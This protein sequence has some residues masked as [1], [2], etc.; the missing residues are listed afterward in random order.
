V[1]SKGRRQTKAGT[2]QVFTCTPKDAT[3]HSFCVLVEVLPAPR[4]KRRGGEP[5]PP[6][7]PV[8]GHEDSWVV[9]K[10]TRTNK[11][12][13]YLLLRCT[14]TTGAAHLFRAVNGRAVAP[15]LALWVPPPRCP[16]HPGAHIVRDGLY[17]NSTNK[18][19]QRYRCYP[20]GRSG[21]HHRFTPT[22]PRAHVHVGHEECAECE[23]QRGM[24]RGDPTIS[25]RQS[26]SSRLVAEALRDL[27]A[28]ASYSM[29]GRRVRKVTKRKRSR[30]SDGKKRKGYPGQ[31]L[32]RN[33]WHIAADWCEIYSP[34]L[35]DH[36]E[37][38]MR[39]RT[40][41]AI[42]ERER[43]VLA[44]QPN[45][46]PLALLIDDIPI[47][48]TFTDKDT[49]RVTRR[50]YF[51]LI[52]AEVRWGDVLDEWGEMR[53]RDLALRLVR[54]YPTNDHHAWKLL[55]DELGYTPDFV[56]ADAGSGLIKGVED[57]YKG[58]VTF[59][60]SLFHVREAIEEGL[61]KTAGAWTRAY[62]G[63]TKELVPA[64]YDHMLGLTRRAVAKMDTSEWSKWWDDL[65]GILAALGL[66][67]AGTR[68]RRKNYEGAVAQILPALTVQPN[69]PLATGGLEVALR[70]KIQPVLVNRSHAF[71]NIE[72]TNRLLDLVVCADFGLFDDMGTVISLLRADNTESEGWSTPLRM[73]SDPQPPGKKPKDKPYSSLR[74]QLLVREIAR[75]KGLA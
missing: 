9:S 69:L 73:V 47:H 24:H 66:P 11:A 33:A 42:K 6:S 54:A 14:P 18:R 20:N 2:K 72:R 50:D 75:Q 71:A 7:C 8:P 36:V 26:W 22:L 61:Y 16:E 32:S 29:T 37:A 46:E 64:L 52:A 23:E 4:P 57:F 55:F 58:A 27:S 15:K 31:R 25:R 67:V 63:G 1:V 70:M 59:I 12:G 53:E 3:A 43:L 34:V 45:P 40:D 35:W 10:G 17:A 38:Q 21:P 51:I 74:D 49:R 5:P 56:I 65:E 60:P 28:G 44:K 30:E 19:R 39:A 13:P 62:E 48:A 68:K 41:A